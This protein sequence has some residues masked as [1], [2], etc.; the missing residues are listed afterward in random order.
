MDSIPKVL[1]KTNRGP[2]S[3]DKILPGD[4]VYDYKTGKPIYVFGITPLQRSYMYRLTYNDKRIDYM[5]E[6]DRILITDPYSKKTKISTLHHA[7]NN[8]NHISLINQHLLEE[9]PIIDNSS[10]VDPYLAGALLI[11]GDHTDPYVNIPIS[12]DQA[13][14]LFSSKYKVC[15]AL[16]INNDRVHFSFYNDPDPI[17]WVNMFQHILKGSTYFQVPYYYINASKEDRWKF[18]RGAFDVAHYNKDFKPGTLAID[19]LCPEVL[20]G[21]QQILWSL[22]VIS[23]IHYSKEKNMKAT[24]EIL[25]SRYQHH[26]FSDNVDII[27]DII[28]NDTGIKL[29]FILGL[30]HI[31]LVGFD[32]SYALITKE[33]NQI[34]LTDNYLPHISF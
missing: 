30:E 28:A 8:M 11:N 5:H 6:D 9:F 15:H 18:V 17:T 21:L 20:Y 4:Q 7:Y 1:I 13:D 22:G 10:Y 16:S 14:G 34:Y 27:R 23:R 3:Y 29:G 26:A 12:K 32:E 19:V 25:N 31:D 24:L 2:L 33:H